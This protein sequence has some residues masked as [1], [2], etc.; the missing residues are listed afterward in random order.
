[1]RHEHADRKGN[2]I[3]PGFR[4]FTIVGSNALAQ[5]VDFGSVL[6]RC[7]VRLPHRLDGLV[8]LRITCAVHVFYLLTKG[9]LYD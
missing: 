4:F 6:C 2:V 1:M 9:R 8:V 5:P 3:L 7:A